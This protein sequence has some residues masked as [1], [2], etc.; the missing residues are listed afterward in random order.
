LAILE[1]C[2]SSGAFNNYSWLGPQSVYSNAAFRQEV[3]IRNHAESSVEFFVRSKNK[4][5]DH[6]GLTSQLPAHEALLRLAT[7]P[8]DACALVAVYDSYGN[9]LKASAIRWFGRE[10]EVRNRAINSI[11]AAIGRRAGS[12]D[13][14]S[15]NASEWVSRVVDAEARRLRKAL[16]AADGQ[17]PYG[18]R[19]M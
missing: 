6:D 5:R 18:R 9:D 2:C 11:L 7:N 8:Q 16:D 10:A 15:M 13:T 4:G 19:T 12:Y 3:V 17:T 14:E 1:R